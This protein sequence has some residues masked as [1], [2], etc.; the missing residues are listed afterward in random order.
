VEKNEGSLAGSIVT[1]DN[2][3]IQVTAVKRASRGEGIIVRLNSL[4][5]PGT[6]VRVT[7]RCIDVARAYLC[8]ARERD[9]HPLE[10]WENSV[11]VAIPGTITTIRMVPD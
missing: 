10:V 4:T 8:D 6:P 3:D 9:L 2:P 1:V 11:L 7:A 5:L